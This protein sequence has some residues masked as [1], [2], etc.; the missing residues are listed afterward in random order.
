MRCGGA[1]AGRAPPAADPLLL[2]PS[3]GQRARPSFMWPDVVVELIITPRRGEGEVK[4]RG[5]AWLGR[6]FLLHKSV[7]WLPGPPGRGRP[8][9]GCFGWSPP[10]GLRCVEAAA[11]RGQKR[12]AGV[13]GSSR[14]AAL[15]CGSA[16]RGRERSPAV[17][18]QVGEQSC[19]R[20]VV[21][22]DRP[23]ARRAPAQRA[24]YPLPG[25]PSLN[26]RSPGRGTY[27][28]NHYFRRFSNDASVV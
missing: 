20:V 13:F 19:S 8:G 22:V 14:C 15:R 6:R 21:M 28:G 26:K 27:G 4:G 7:V 9:L 11:K 1:P 25:H 10:R 2:Q 3:Q 23:A 17:A 24:V 5:V 12:P 18:S 16:R